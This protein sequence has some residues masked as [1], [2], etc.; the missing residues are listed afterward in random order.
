MLPDAERIAVA[1]EPQQREDL[2]RDAHA[3][4]ERAEIVW[5]P[6]EP[7]L[8]AGKRRAGAVSLFF[9]EDPVYHFTS[10]G[11]LRRAY[12][13]GLLY[14]AEGGRLFEIERVRVPGAVEM[15]SRPLTAT[16]EAHFLGAM[17]VKLRQ[18]LDAFDRGAHAVVAQYPAEGTV[19][20]SLFQF[21]RQRLAGPTIIAQSPHVG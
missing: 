2:M 17:T 10:E 3:L 1:R 21:V 6:D 11:K 8:I 19:A 13:A 4:V 12:V 5:H 7:P 9:G 15:R 14:K 20:R 18:A 16:E